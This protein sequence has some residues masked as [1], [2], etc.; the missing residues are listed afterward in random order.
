MILTLGSSH[1]GPS[2]GLYSLLVTSVVTAWQERPITQAVPFD[3]LD[4]FIEREAQAAGVNEAEAFPF[5]IEGTPARL[6]WHVIDGS[7]IPSDAHGH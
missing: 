5:R 4:A 3:Q 2:S 7:K 6:D 1:K